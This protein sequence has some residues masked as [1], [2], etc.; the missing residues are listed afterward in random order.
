MSLF[1]LAEIF[2]RRTALN[3]CCHMQRSVNLFRICFCSNSYYYAFDT[4]DIGSFPNGL[5]VLAVD[6]YSSFTFPWSPSEI[7]QNVLDKKNSLTSTMNLS[8]SD[9]NISYVINA[10][11]I[12]TLVVAFSSA[13]VRKTYHKYF[14]LDQPEY[15]FKITPMSRTSKSH[16]LFVYLS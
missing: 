4:E 12:F 7:E 15:M 3:E 1:L 14:R 13:Y 8:D 6:N 16:F 11:S 9:C 10:C 2:Q 5:D